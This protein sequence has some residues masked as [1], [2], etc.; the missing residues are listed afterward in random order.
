MKLKSTQRKVVEVD[1][2]DELV[3]T[4]YGKPYSFQ[5]QD[6]CQGRGTFSLI[7]PDPDAEDFPNETVPEDVN[8]KERGVKFSAWLKR[9]PKQHLSSDSCGKEIWAIDL[10]WFRNFYP[11]IQMVANDLHAK[12]L[13]E[14]GEYLIN[15]DW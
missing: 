7:V 5:Q 1:N 9:D 15:I 11:S 14:A 13:L 12:G 8:H 4:T 3:K 10:W 2:W 6:G